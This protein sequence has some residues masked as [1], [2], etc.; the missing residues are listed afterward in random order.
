MEVLHGSL[1]I[2]YLPSY[3]TQSGFLRWAPFSTEAGPVPNP[4]QTTPV[5]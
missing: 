3:S 4:D 5:D 2:S 1:L